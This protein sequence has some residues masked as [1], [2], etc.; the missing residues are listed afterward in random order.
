MLRKE[1]A[2]I[3]EKPFLL[4]FISRCC[5]NEV[6]RKRTFEPKDLATFEGDLLQTIMKQSFTFLTKV[7]G[8]PICLK[9]GG[10]HF[11]ASFQDFCCY[12]TGS[13]GVELAYRLEY[14]NKRPIFVGL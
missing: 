9:E 5:C 2:T 8:E 12:K 10:W 6:F 3:A 11:E 14:G 13:I 1:K 4:V 7:L